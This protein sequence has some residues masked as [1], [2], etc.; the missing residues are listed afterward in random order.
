MNVLML[1]RAKKIL[2]VPVAVA[3]LV[4]RS[5]HLKLVCFLLPFVLRWKP[6]SLSYLVGNSCE[7]RYLP[8]DDERIGLT[9]NP[10]DDFINIPSK[11]LNFDEVNLI[12]RG[13]S[14]CHQEINKSLPTFF[15]N[16][17]GKEDL[18]EYRVKWLATADPEIFARNMG[19]FNDKSFYKTRSHDCG[20][21]FV[22]SG[23]VIMPTQDLSVNHLNLPK[24]Q[25]DI[26][27]SL[28]GSNIDLI[29]GDFDC[30]VVIHRSRLK[31]IQLGSGVAVLVALLSISKNINIYGWD[32]YC[33]D[34][35]PGNYYSQVKCLGEKKDLALSNVITSL[36]NWIYA[37]RIMEHY[38]DRVEVNGRISAVKGSDW[39]PNYAYK[40]LYKL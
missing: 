22:A 16:I 38:S 9:D 30:S 21:F 15:L 1:R 11:F 4:I 34:E 14:L 6:Q 5:Y 18:D 23:A 31:N 24:V 36:L 35:L 7:W 40:V 25:S 3:R 28:A 32:Q 17:D 33:C 26:L 20:V 13:Q 12:F 29:A 27:R 19:L 39:I 10:L 37:Y 8:R 2:K